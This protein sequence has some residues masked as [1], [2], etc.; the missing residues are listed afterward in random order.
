MQAMEGHQ[1]PTNNFFNVTSSSYCNSYS[2]TTKIGGCKIEVLWVTIME[3]IEMDEE[4]LDVLTRGKEEK[5]KV[6]RCSVGRAKQAYWK[7][8]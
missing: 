5:K 3:D 8:L 6:L 1:R 4:H 2:T 7:L